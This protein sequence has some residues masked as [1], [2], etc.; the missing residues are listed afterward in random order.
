MAATKARVENR[1]KLAKPH[2]RITLYPWEHWLVGRKRLVL[3]RGRDFGE[4]VQ[5]HGMVSMVRNAAKRFRLSVSV[6]VMGDRIDVTINGPLPSPT[7]IRK[8]KVSR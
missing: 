4:Y 2:G 5:V 6:R 8:P 3:I 1:S 7:P